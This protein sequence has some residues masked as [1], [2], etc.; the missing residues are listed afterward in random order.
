MLIKIVAMFRNLIISSFDATIRVKRAFHPALA[1]R[2][3]ASD[4]FLVILLFPKY[5]ESYFQLVHLSRKDSQNL[6]V[7]FILANTV[8]PLHNGHLGDRRRW[9]LW[10]GGRYGEV[11]V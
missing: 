6:N 11:G 2:G 8:E 9:P 7:H 5:F 1:S 3:F 10:R 4:V